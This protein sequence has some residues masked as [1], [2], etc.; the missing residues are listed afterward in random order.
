MYPI[1]ARPKIVTDSGVWNIPDTTAI[2]V[3]IALGTIALTIGVLGI[4]SSQ[5]IPLGPFNSLC[6]QIPFACRTLAAGVGGSFILGSLGVIVYKAIKTHRYLNWCKSDG[7]LKNPPKL[8]PNIYKALIID[9]EIPPS[10][11]TV[12]TNDTTFAFGSIESFTD[13][14]NELENKGYKNFQQP[15]K[16]IQAA[17]PDPLSEN[18]KQGHPQMY[19]LGLTVTIISLPAFIIPFFC[20]FPY[21]WTVQ[22]AALG[23]LGATLYGITNDQFALRQCKSYFTLGHTEFHK[24]LLKTDNPTLNGIVWGIHATWMLGAVAGVVLAIAA[25]VTHS[26]AINPLYFTPLS[27]A[28]SLAVNVYT[29]V[30]SKKMENACKHPIL[31]ERITHYFNETKLDPMNSFYETVHLKNV[32]EE[33]RTGWLAVGTRNNLSYMAMPALG[34]ALAVGIVAARILLVIL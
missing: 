10:D 7:D 6:A 12:F 14:I 33:E 21:A 26:Y 19:W 5:G 18:S 3:S 22:T 23:V 34:I 27:I 16:I 30:K 24:R 32:P 17:K 25:T 29:H 2:I 15:K 13:K 31:K 8:G 1:G 11:F 28:G 4:L 20:P 9:K